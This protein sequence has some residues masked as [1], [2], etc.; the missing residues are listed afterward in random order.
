MIFSDP[1]ENGKVEGAENH[2]SPRSFGM[3]W[4]EDG[5]SAHDISH[6]DAPSCTLSNLYNTIP[7]YDLCAEEDLVLDME[8]ELLAWC[9]NMLSISPSARAMLKDTIEKDWSVMLCHDL[10]HDFSLN[11]EEQEIALRAEESN[12]RVWGRSSYYRHAL[13]INFV[14]ALRD[15]WQET[16]HG[17]FEEQYNAEGI[18]MMERIRAADIDVMA[19]YIAW[20]LRGEGFG[21]I[22]RH[23]LGSDLGDMAMAF[24][25]YLERDPTSLFS[26]AALSMCFKQWYASKDRINTCDHETLEYLDEV[27]EQNSAMRVFGHKKPVRLNV[28]IMSCM[29]DKTAYLRG[30]GDNILTDPYFAGLHDDIN[31]A[32]LMH[33]AYDM[34]VVRV[35]DVP[36]R[37]ADL[38]SRIFPK[39]ADDFF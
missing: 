33:L 20:E 16:R 6:E 22:W 29:P 28:E 14:R 8:K 18:L 34:C 13:L 23:V 39:E 12:I 11:V 32:H 24:S 3:I 30:Q 17:A 21:D 27:L 7:H 19:I 26:G 38:A 9:V 35:G 5:V 10:D 4:D 1:S 36:F 15:V 37:N 25:T 2:T 31:Q